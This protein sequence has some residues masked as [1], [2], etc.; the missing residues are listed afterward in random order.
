MGKEH[1]LVTGPL[2]GL[3]LVY[4]RQGRNSEALV[5]LNRAQGID[6]KQIEH[7]LGF[8]AEAQQDQFLA[9]RAVNVHLYLSLIR[10]RF[11]DNPKALRGALDLWLVRKGILLEAQK[12]IKDVL[13]SGESKHAREIFSNLVRV[14]Q[15]LAKLILGEPGK[16]SPE[17]YQKRITELTGKKET[18]EGQLSRLSQSFAQKQKTTTATT[19]EIAAALPPKTAL[20]EF[21]RIRDWNFNEEKWT[22]HRYLAFVLQAG[23][24]DAISLIDLGE[25]DLIDQK[26]AALKKAITDHKTSYDTLARQS[27]ALYQLIFAPLKEA[28]GKTKHVFLSP[29]GS[30]NL[31]P[32][33]ILRSPEG[34]YLVETNI[35]NYV[36]AGRDIAGFGIVKEKGKRVLLLGDPDFDL[37]AQPIT[38]GGKK[39]LTRSWNMQGINFSR[40]PGTKEEVN[41][42][43]ALLGRSTCDTYTGTAARESVLLEK[44]NPRILHLA[45]H[46]FFLSDQDWSSIM[47][48]K[49]RGITIIGKD[50]SAKINTIRIENSFLRSG[51]ALAG[52]NSSLAYDGSTE[53][54]LTAEKIITLTLRGT[55][56]VVLSACNTGVGDV[57]SGEGVYGLRRAF[58]QA[59]AKS[60]VMSM[61]EVPD[62]ETK[63]LM[64][65]F[66][67]NLQS[68]KM[69]R[70]EALRNAALKQRQT[71]KIRYGFDHPYY[72]GA[73]VFLG[74]A[75]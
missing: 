37:A 51:L 46:G 53:G 23:K 55:D 75:E 13:A 25:A 24:G 2:Y 52:A 33:E 18:F 19:S 60:L 29:D 35:L 73:F 16:E 68:G 65:C 10:Q 69:N 9:V 62:R 34:L 43:A 64:V 67:K 56:M 58:T 72:W 17:T 14:R 38:D 6:G 49:S 63:E 41:A 45:T 1:P 7:V 26:V 15:E 4:N 47:D 30:L 5:L 66:Y 12:R 11:L 44:K 71:V 50:K 70:A 48:N 59:G 42:I 54:I 27:T 39:T 74:E 32:F 40:L 61:W 28:I 20:I 3:S 36:A 57:K 31:I 22:S 21:A 8:A